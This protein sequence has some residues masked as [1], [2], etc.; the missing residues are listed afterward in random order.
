MD[1]GRHP[2]PRATCSGDGFKLVRKEP[3][4]AS[5]LFHHVRSSPRQLVNL[6]N[7]AGESSIKTLQASTSC[8]FEKT[9]IKCVYI[10]QHNDIDI[11][12]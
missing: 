7:R 10:Q 12:K 4:S 2:L 1:T 5:T 9:A 8:T 6:K 11:G 3:R